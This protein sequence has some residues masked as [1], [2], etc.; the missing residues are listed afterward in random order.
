[1]LDTVVLTL[2][3]GSYTIDDST[4]F[5]PSDKRIIDGG[6]SR[7]YKQVMQIPTNKE[8]LNGFYKPRLTISNRFTKDH[9][10]EPTLK[11]ELS[12]PKM[13]YGNNFDELTQN[14]YIP[15]TEKLQRTMQSMGVVVNSKDIENAPI[16][17]IH[18]SK[19][20]PLTDGTTPQSLISKIKEANVNISLDI[21]QTDYRNDGQSLKWHTNSYEVA[22]YDKIKDLEM[23]LKSDKRSIERDN[24]IQFN[25]SDSF[26]I[27]KQFEVIRMEVRLNKRQKIQQLFQNLKVESDLTY[28]NLFNPS[29][30]QK[31]LLHYLDECDGKRFPLYDYKK[32]TDKALL[33]D[34]IINNP[35]LSAKKTLLLFGIKQAFDTV[36]PRELRAMF[37]NCDTRTWYRLAE[38]AKEI[39]L[40]K[41]QSPFAVIRDNLTQFKPLRLVDFQDRMINNDKY[42]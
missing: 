1:M 2:N 8:M 32:T 13:L 40:P 10:P 12:L 21:N 9:R 37:G 27:R 19:N 7:S 23:A 42:D 35:K 18:Y 29:I 4:R 39:C 25:L 24:A 36:N 6:E 11:V 38:E 33:S 3:K 31:V 30:S 14:D 34:L 41:A 22:F 16:S 15:V 28:Q 26:Q 17:A 5:I 20:M